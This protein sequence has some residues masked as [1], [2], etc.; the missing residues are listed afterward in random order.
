MK[1]GG[2]IL[3]YILAAKNP[4][5]VILTLSISL[6]SP[7]FIQS[8]MAVDKENPVS[9][10]LD[11]E[12]E[13]KINQ[14]ALVGSE[15]IKIKFL[16]VTQDSR[17]P[18]DVKCAWQGQAVV[19]VN[20]KQ[21]DQELGDF[22]L[23]SVAG[24]EDAA[25]KKFIGQQIKLV[26][27]SPYPVSTRTIQPSDYVATFIVSNTLDKTILISKGSSKQGCEKIE[28]CFFPHSITVKPDTL[29]TWINMDSESHTVTSGTIKD[30]PDGI[31]GSDLISPGDSFSHRFTTGNPQNYYCMIHPWMIGSV[32]VEFSP[33]DINQKIY[34][35]QQATM[36]K[37]VIIEIQ[38]TEPTAF[39]QL[40]MHAY[41][42]NSTDDIITD[43]N[44]D[45][46]VTQ[47]KVAVLDIKGQY[48]HTGIDEHW[49]DPLHSDSPVDVKV[50]IL[51]IGKPGDES[52]WF[53]PKGDA[54]VFS[55]VP[56]F[57][58]AGLI[59]VV[60][61]VAILFVTTMQSKRL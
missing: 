8:V 32:T 57:P 21:N 33:F 52:N 27:V 13:L 39:E 9:A 40:G 44:Y 7:G 53:G 58:I 20:I 11:K 35:E 38:T 60:S 23:T 41:F 50:T 3:K 17:C 19:T 45:I 29:V 34:T 43:I 46:E 4:A 24:Q 26:N 48:S 10:T 22:K 37:S 15:N 28:T 49:T 18:S 59:M 61:M 16:N 54:V 12:F 47:N 2:S 5:I 6:Y 56:E 55:A 36:D 51:G 31:F 25:I 42:R 1:S 30:G 14:T